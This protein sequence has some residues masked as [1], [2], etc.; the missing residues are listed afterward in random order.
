MIKQY[1]MKII[2][3][4][5]IE[6]E[7]LKIGNGICVT[8]T[9]FI[10]VAIRTARQKVERWKKLNSRQ[11][12]AYVIGEL[13]GITFGIAFFAAL[14]WVNGRIAQNLYI[15]FIFGALVFGPAFGK[16]LSQR[17]GSYTATQA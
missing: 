12:Y 6:D 13:F 14:G 10:E 3:Y 1:W 4:D 5:Q 9:A 16:T 17:Y 15:G 7:L 8:L 11:K 2:S